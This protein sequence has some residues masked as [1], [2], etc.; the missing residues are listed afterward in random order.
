VVTV[1]SS[2]P[3]LVLAARNLQVNGFPPS[4]LVEADV[5]ADLRRRRALG[6]RFELIVVDPPKLAG[7]AAQVRRASRAYKDLNL[8]ALGLLA[9]GGHLVT[10][11][12]SG[13]VDEALFQKIVFAA[14]LDA[15]R[16]VQVVGRLT[17]AADHPV[18]LSFPEGAYLKGLVCRAVG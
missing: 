3:A 1:D 7:S 10:F 4:G 12:C 5:F 16:E 11:S 13:A 8:Q 6:E 2:R 18:L 9:P 14:A 15:N 17:Q